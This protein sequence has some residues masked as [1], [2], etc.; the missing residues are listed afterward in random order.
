MRLIG[1]TVISVY[2]TR[3]STTYSYLLRK[4]HKRLQLMSVNQTNSNDKVK[5]EPHSE[6]VVQA[7]G[8]FHKAPAASHQSTGTVQVKAGEM[9]R[10]APPN[11]PAPAVGTA[12][13]G[14]TK[15]A[16]QNTPAP[17]VGM[18]T[19]GV[20]KV[21]PGNTTAPAV[22]MATSGVPKVAPQN[23]PAPAVGM[24]TSGVP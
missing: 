8:N 18:A 19:S 17:V 1:N 5:L 16:P 24:A 21:K 22:G 13:S 23:T 6:S 20:P 14:V 7:E 9:S 2:T 15:V 3:S 4:G 12:T 11:T 10:V